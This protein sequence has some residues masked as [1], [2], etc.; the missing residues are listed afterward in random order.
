MS[1]FIQKE[2]KSAT[3]EKIMYAVKNKGERFFPIGCSVI[4]MNA[5]T[6]PGTIY[7]TIVFKIVTNT[8]F[9]DGTEVFLIAI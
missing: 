9:P 2:N 7:E 5:N 6:Q 4:Q 3:I 1:I 8:A